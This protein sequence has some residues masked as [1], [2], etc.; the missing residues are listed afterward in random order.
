LKGEVKE[1]E[2]INGKKV[3]KTPPTDKKKLGSKPSPKK[4]K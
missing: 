4:K 3:N 1:G 2:W